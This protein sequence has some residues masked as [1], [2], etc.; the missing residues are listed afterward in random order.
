[1]LLT[2]SARLEDTGAA[3]STG[4]FL[5]LLRFAL[6]NLRITAWA[7]GKLE[8]LT[9]TVSYLYYIYDYSYRI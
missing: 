3:F 9:Q 4:I 7:N 8:M 5:Y 1:M 6:S 2:T